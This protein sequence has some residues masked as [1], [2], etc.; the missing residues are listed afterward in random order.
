MA[1]NLGVKKV[2][3]VANKIRGSEDRSFIKDNVRGDIVGFITFSNAL[4]KADMQGASPYLFSKET[5]GEA[6]EIKKNI[7]KALG[8]LP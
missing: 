3:V 7:E 6:A 5:L 2:F 4:M 1:E 8:F